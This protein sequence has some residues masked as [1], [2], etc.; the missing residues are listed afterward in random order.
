MSA[1]MGA[2]ISA[3]ISAYMSAYIGA[4]M[5]AYIGNNAG[6][7]IIGAHIIGAHIISTR[8]ET[9]AESN[10]HGSRATPR[11]DVLRGATWSSTTADTPRGRPAQWT[12]GARD[13]NPRDKRHPR[14]LTES[15]RAVAA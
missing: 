12:Q 6:A 4:Y 1:Y 13:S 11:G 9:N 14:K 8:A 5:S 10:V 2:Y 3:Y 7:H 15:F